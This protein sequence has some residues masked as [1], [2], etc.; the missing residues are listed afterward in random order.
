MGFSAGRW[1]RRDS[2]ASAQGRLGGSEL[3]WMFRPVASTRVAMEAGAAAV[4]GGF[5]ERVRRGLVVTVFRHGAWW[6]WRRGRP[7][8]QRGSSGV[9]G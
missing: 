7:L 3:G 1:W 4:G 6:R 8:V 5:Q 9:K 2:Q